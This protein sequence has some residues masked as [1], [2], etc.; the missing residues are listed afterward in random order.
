MPPRLAFYML[1]TS[2]VA[3]NISRTPWDEMC[4]I[5]LCFIST[6]L[7]ERRSPDAP[8]LNREATLGQLTSRMTL[9]LED[10]ED[11]CARNLRPLYKEN[12]VIVSHIQQAIAILF[13][14]KTWIT[15]PPDAGS[16]EWWKKMHNILD[17]LAS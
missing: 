10:I 5:F 2:S 17:F 3:P 15:P 16:M 6:V 14:N 1:K 9:L 12:S 4:S 8:P 7:D 11:Y 13:P